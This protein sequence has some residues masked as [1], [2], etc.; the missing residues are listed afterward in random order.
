MKFNIRA[1]Q[2]NIIDFRADSCLGAKP[3]RGSDRL[4][5]ALTS[6][7]SV[8]V[9]SVL[10]GCGVLCVRCPG[11][12]GVAVCVRGCQHGCCW[13]GTFRVHARLLV[14]DFRVRHA[15]RGL[16]TPLR[17]LRN[18]FVVSSRR[19]FYRVNHCMVLG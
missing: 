11:V 1:L 5:P 3:F 8:A 2:C 17:T 13:F 19:G 6:V 4:C 12:S 14:A 9:P 15:W 10:A 16:Y 7:W 18:F